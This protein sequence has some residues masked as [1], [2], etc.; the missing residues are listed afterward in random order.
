LNDAKILL[1]ALLHDLG[2]VLERTKE[3]RSQNLPLEF[4]KV[5]YAH[6]KFSAFFLN[7]LLK[8]KEDLSPFLKENLTEEVIELVLNHHDPKNDYGLIIQIADWLSSSEREEDESQKDLYLT[9]P[10]HNP[11]YKIDESTRGFYYE[12]S[13]LEKSEDLF[14]KKDD[15]KITQI[16]YQNLTKNFLRSFPKVNDIEQLLTLMEYYFSQVPAQTTGFIADISIYDH[17]RITGAI[18]HALYKDYQNQR[19]TSKDLIE[20]REDLRSKEKNYSPLLDKPLFTL[21]SGD[22]SGIQSFIFNV[23]SERAGRMLKGKSVFLD[24]LSRYSAKFILENNNFTK[25]NAIYIGGGNF[26]LLLSFIEDQKLEEL[27]EFISEN[28]FKLTGEDLYLA[29]EWI[30][31]SINDLFNFF[32]KRQELINKLDERKRRKFSEL[33][34]FYDLILYP[35]E[36]NVGESEYCIICGKRMAKEIKEGERLCKTCN[37]FVELTNSLKRAKFLIEK[38]SSFEGVPQTWNEFFEKLGYKLDFIKEMKSTGYNNEKIYLLEEVII[39]DNFIPHGFLLGSYTI[40]ESDFES[41]AKKN[42][43]NGY[44]DQKLAYLKMDADNMGNIFKKLADEEKTKER[45]SLTRYGVLSRRIELFFGKIVMEKIKNNDKIYP[46]FVG[47][48]DLF[49]IGTYE[50]INELALKIREEF[51][52]YTGDSKVFSL[53]SGLYYLPDNFPLIRGASLVENALEK[54]KQ[55]KYPEEEK[56]KKDKICVEDEVLTYR[57]FKEAKEIAKGIA[58]KIT[59][60]TKED[61][62]SRAVITK[63]E[64]S[65]KGFNPLLEQ[66]LKGKISPPAIWRFKY[67]LRLYPDI[68]ERLSDIILENVLR[69]GEDKIRNPRLI[70]VATKIAKMKTRKSRGDENNER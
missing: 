17:A 62:A 65:L 60:K 48:D 64:N 21:I 31:L 32:D 38:K 66:S 10:L 23:S 3:Y 46:V 24:L 27:R 1:S 20:I 52:R 13:S 50:K 35:K 11:F 70:L 29:I 34:N 53:S 56:P 9:I 5:K 25:A 43:E 49:I 22:L 37:S 54:A 68:A 26:D 8:Q 28:I 39:K 33:K 51:K 59:K 42:I 44:G 67:Y 19:I 4:Q 57:E 14:P 15:V 40:E 36:E 41:I 6:P 55:F 61:K 47:G 16:N 30:H 18:A 69:K 45:L 2:K 58:D 7:T 12:L 63:I